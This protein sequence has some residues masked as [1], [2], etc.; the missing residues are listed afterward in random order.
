ML[1]G[2]TYAIRTLS[3]E[4]LP[5]ALDYTNACVTRLNALGAYRFNWSPR[6]SYRLMSEGWLSDPDLLT[7]LDTPA[8]RRCSGDVYARLEPPTQTTPNAASAHHHDG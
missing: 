6:E 5:H 3:F 7:A 4:Y 2:L 8:A 1:A